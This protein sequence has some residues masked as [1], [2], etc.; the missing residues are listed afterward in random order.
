MQI[1]MQIFVWIMSIIMSECIF[2][3]Y[4]FTA[5]QITQVAQPIWIALAG[6]FWQQ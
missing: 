1:F 4:V 5:A 2:R 3:L 6:Q